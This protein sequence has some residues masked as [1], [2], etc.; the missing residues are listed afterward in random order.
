[1]KF[2]EKLVFLYIFVLGI[3]FT[4]LVPPLQKP[5]EHGHFK[6]A[7]YLRQGYVFLWNDGKKLP[8]DKQLYDLINNSSLNKIPYRPSIKFN[9]EI[10]NVPL[11]VS[12]NELKPVYIHEKA[13]FMLGA[14]AYIPHAVGLF[15]ARILHLNAFV[16]FFMG[17]L[18]MFIFSLIAMIFIYKKTL[19]PYK[20]ILL[21]VFS[22]PMTLH[23]LSAYNYD[24]MH[25]IMGFALFSIF[26]TLHTQKKITDKNL[27]WLGV[28]AYLYLISKVVYEPM[29]FLILLLPFKK[30][31]SNI[32]V[33]TKKISLLMISVFFFYIILKLPIYIAT[34]DY[35]HP[36]G[37]NPLQ[38]VSHILQNPIR[39]VEIF[40]TSAWNLKKFHLQSA[41]GIFGWLDYSLDAWMYFVWI[42][43]S[44]VLIYKLELNKNEHMTTGSTI[45]LFFILF[46]EYAYIQTFFYLN[47][48]TV[49]SPVIDG[50]Q[51]RYFISLLPFAF[52]GILQIKYNITLKKI[53]V[54]MGV[55][56]FTFLVIRK[57]LLRYYS[58]PF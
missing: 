45:F 22:L 41:I 34:P 46:L 24:G 37:V 11:L 13:E 14:F 57:I 40:L 15:I 54:I 18:F 47:W 16:S 51:G 50:T 7:I 4:F 8:L 32:K 48:K 21:L 23:Q 49:G 10:Y 9:P 39:Y 19:S 53:V 5:D 27:F 58:I 30:I 55:L 35:T 26:T 1:M 42:F 31:S 52:L 12:Q 33:S 38:Q 29:V 20:Y 44:I 36:I 43:A 6:R 3:A 28:S 25:L 17:R 56:L 2:T